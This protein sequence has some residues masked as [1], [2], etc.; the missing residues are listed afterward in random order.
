ME[1][2][3]VGRHFCPGCEPE[4]DQVAEILTVSWCKPHAP[5]T[6]GTADA[7]MPEWRFLSGTA[8]AEASDCRAVARLIR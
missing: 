8:E 5:S 7:G 1:T 3:F 6:E 4:A 2:P